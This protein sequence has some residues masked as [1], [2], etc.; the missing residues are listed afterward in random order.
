MAAGFEKNCTVKVLP[1]VLF[2]LPLTMVPSRPAL[3]EA[4]T[5]K[6]C[7]R[8]GSTSGSSSSLSVRPSAARAN[9]DAVEREAVDN[10]PAHHH[11]CCPDVEPV[12]R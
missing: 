5:G 6:F 1:G 12:H 7:R 10:E 11:V 8:L 3:A 4:R 9:V 2:S